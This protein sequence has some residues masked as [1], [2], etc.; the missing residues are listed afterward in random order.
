MTDQ[1][2]TS[3]LVSEAS[4]NGMTHTIEITAIVEG[5][6]HHFDIVMR[7]PLVKTPDGGDSEPCR[8]AMDFHQ[9]E[10]VFFHDQLTANPIKLEGD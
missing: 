3:D 7:G 1:I 9:N 4:S 5:Y 8:L 10:C 6:I 2:V